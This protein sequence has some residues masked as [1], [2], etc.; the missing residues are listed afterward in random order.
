MRTGGRGGGGLD[1]PGFELI[2]N[3]SVNINAYTAVNIL[4]HLLP[5]FTKTQYRY[6]EGKTLAY[7]RSKASH[8]SMPLMG[9]VNSKFCTE[10]FSIN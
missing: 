7:L 1:P 10:I 3:T 9:S 6:E 8:L 4:K 2:I 5:G